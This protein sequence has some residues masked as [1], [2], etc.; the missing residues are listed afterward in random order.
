M[1]SISLINLRWLL[2]SLGLVLTLHAP[3][4]TPWVPLLALALGAWRY[5]LAYRRHPLPGIKILLPITLIG[6]L[7]ILVSYGGMFGRDAGVALLTLMMALKTM[8]TATRRDMTLL[9]YLGFFLCICVFLFSQSIPIA[10]FMLLPVVMLTATLIG[11]NHASG[12]LPAAQKLKLAGSM[13]MQAAPLMLTLFLLFP[14]VPGPLWG[15][16]QDMARGVTGLSDDM[17]PGSISNLSR[18]DA[19]A[20]R[21]TFRGA[22]PPASKLYWRGPVL[23]NYDGRSWRAGRTPQALVQPSFKAITPPVAYTVTLEP[24]NRPWLF[25]LELPVMLPAGGILTT[26][27]QYLAR[28]PIRQRLRY[29]AASSLNYNE[30]GALDAPTRQRALQL[31]LFGNRR[32]RALAEQWRAETDDPQQL[33]QRAL[34][35]YNADFTYTMTPP[36]LGASAVDGFLFDTRKGFCEH[37]AGS[38]VFLMRASGVPARV[39]TGYQGGQPNPMAD[40]LIVRQ[41]DAHAWAE[42]WLENRGWMR[43]DPTAAVSPQRIEYGIAAALSLTEPLPAMARLELTWIRRLGLGWDAVNNGWNQWV[44]GYNQQLQM[45]F[46]SRLAGSH[47]NWG[48]MALWLSGLL[49][50]MVGAIAAFLLRDAL[51]GTDPVQQQWMRFKKKLAHA[52]V[53]SFPQEGPNDFMRRAARRLP[54]VGRSIER[55]GALYIG[56]R[57]GGKTDLAELQR[58]VREFR[59]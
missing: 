34:A 48:D 52:C 55:I 12:E 20:F 31:P 3:N 42:V 18:S 36:P 27:Y 51:P 38:F 57:Y 45:E 53:P 59:A 2:V 30:G 16:S 47:V 14:R 4:L 26:D 28:R 54:H 46:L 37:Y 13:L 5:A 33:V 44:L 11:L 21:V 19:V 1:Q 23:W 35:M 43:V 39:V 49:A 6:V 58:L 22:T 24:H 25:M 17:S 50:V 10:T 9:V 32:A 8:E 7:G 29:D 41:S 56:L 40:Y 15:L